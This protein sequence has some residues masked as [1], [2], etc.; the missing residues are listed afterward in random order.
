M[1]NGFSSDVGSLP[2]SSHHTGCTIHVSL[3][4]MSGHSRERA[5][6]FTSET[7]PI[8]VDNRKPAIED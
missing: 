6:R 7:K 3:T 2:S 8:G 5:N 4:A 1:S